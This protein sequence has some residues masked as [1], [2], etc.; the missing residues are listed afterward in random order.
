MPGL[1][2]VAHRVELAGL[3]PRIARAVDHERRHAQLAEPAAVEI[4][5]RRRADRPR[6]AARRR[7]WSGSDRASRRRARARGRR[8]RARRGRPDRASSSRRTRATP[9]CSA[10][11]CAA[12]TMRPLSRSGS[13]SPIRSAITAPSLC[14][15]TTGRSSSQRVDHRERFGGGAMVKVGLLPLEP[16]PTAVAGPIRGDDAMPGRKRRDLSIERIDLVAPAAVQDHDRRA[17]RRRRG[18]AREPAKPRAQAR[19]KRDRC[20]ARMTRTPMLR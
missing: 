13:D 3:G 2:A 17:R 7:R 5:R 1:S 18:S 4:G 8:S 14:P 9:A 11:K 10:Q 20:T 19:T 15:Q 16:R 12:S 6:S